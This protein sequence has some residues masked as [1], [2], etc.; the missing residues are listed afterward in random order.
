M[1]LYSLSILFLLLS[2]S[3]PKKHSYSF[4]FWRTEWNL[5]QTEQK[6]L[7][8][9]QATTTYTR[10]FDVDKIG[11]KFRSVGKIEFSQK[12][13]TNIT[14]VIFITNRTFFDIKKDKIQ[15]LAKSIFSLIQDIKIKNNLTL[16]SEIQ[17]DCDWTEQTRDD[18]FFFL[19]ALKKISQQEITATLRLHQVKDKDKTGIPPLNKVYLMC[20]AT[21]SPL[22]N[23]PK[24]SILDVP[25]LK[26][27]LK[28]I[29]KYP[30]KMDIALP[31]YSWG[32]V[33][34]HI[35]KKKIIN[36]LTIKDLANNKNFKKISETEFEVL[37]EDFY[38]GMYFSKGFRIKIEEIS[39]NQLDEVKQFLDKKINNYHIVYYHLDS[40]FVEKYKL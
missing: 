35:G 34:N 9:A 33:T 16:S 40:K 15:F 29:D 27:Y 2:C 26:N 3:N 37:N 10:F 6:A 8:K 23:Q 25:T 19:N 1:K 36:A 12:S 4:Y 21:Y 20:Y 22:E 5:D 11:N 17:I 38:F 7:Q 39:Q 14:P 32:I 24:N 28:D 13:N 30:L 31:L 18:Y